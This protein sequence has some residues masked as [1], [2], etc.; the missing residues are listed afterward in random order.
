MQSNRYHYL[1]SVSLLGVLSVLTPVQAETLRSILKYS[2]VRDPVLLEAKADKEGA[3]NRVEQAKSLHYPQ[4]KL[5]GNSVLAEKHDKKGDYDNNAITPGLEVSLNLY[6]FGAI[7]AEIAKNKFSEQYYQHKYNESR[8]ELGYTIGDLYL[9]AYD[10]KQAIRLLKRSLQRHQKILANIGIIVS[11]DTGR[12]S[13]YVQAKARKILVTQQINDTQRLLDSSLSSLSKYTGKSVSAKTLQN[14]FKGLTQNLLKKRYTLKE[15]Q[16]SPTFLAQQAELESKIKDVE[17]EKA[18]KKPSIDLVGFATPDDQQI[19]LRFSWDVFNRS[20]N[21]TVREK[22]SLRA[23]AESRLQRVVRDIDETARLALI[24][25]KRSEIQLRTL[26]AQAKATGK[27][28][29]FYKLQF[30]VA[31]RSLIEVLNAEKELTDVELAQLAARTQWNRAALSYLRSQGKIADWVGLA[32]YSPTSSDVQVVDKK[33]DRPNE[34]TRLSKTALSE[35][36]TKPKLVQQAQ[37]TGEDIELASVDEGLD[38]AEQSA[39]QTQATQQTVRKKGIVGR[40]LTTIGLGEDVA[41]DNA[42]DDKNSYQATALRTGKQSAIKRPAIKRPAIKQSLQQKAMSSQSVQANIPASVVDAPAADT[43]RQETVR[44]RGIFGRLLAKAGLLKDKSQENQVI[45]TVVNQP[46]EL[47]STDDKVNF[48]LRRGLRQ[49]KMVTP[50]KVNRS[51][52]SIKA[53]KA[54]VEMKSPQPRELVRE[55]TKGLGATPKKDVASRA[56]PKSVVVDKPSQSVAVADKNIE[57]S[58]F[59]EEAIVMQPPRSP[60]VDKITAKK[61]KI[62]SERQPPVALSGETV[63]SEPLLEENMMSSPSKKAQSIN[64]I[65]AVDSTEHFIE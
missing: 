6:A 2:L 29:D 18:K 54:T 23:A 61:Q 22:N 14:P 4:V 60:A 26:A 44:E 41:Q 57:L 27:V 16:K 49:E 53:D 35:A 1:L 28:V 5:T 33:A 37:Q 65:D 46:I 12:R 56:L 63:S 47:A 51:V 9:T 11:N 40:F 21:Y 25:M 13:E 42:A 7:D 45:T 24:E 30:S 43:V 15:K 17:A 8:E 34:S 32:D 59:A 52:R 62:V 38:A 64:L 19:G 55:P 20:T 50:K 31:R 58:S 39:G 48:A 36:V 10:A 3:Y